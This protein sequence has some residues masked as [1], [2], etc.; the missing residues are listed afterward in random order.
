MALAA[1]VWSQWPTEI[2]ADLADRGHDIMDWHRGAMT[3]RRLLVLLDNAPDTGPYM[4]ARRDGR[5]SRGERV[6]EETFNEI[7]LLRAAFYAVNGDDS[8][9]YEPTILV[10]PID[11]LER[12]R[13]QA[14]DDA[15]QERV[16]AEFEAEIGFS[17]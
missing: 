10:D 5:Q 9:V 12:A 11:E 14:M 7:A 6:R 13:L 1:L 3:S 4:R 2:E 16:T 17:I 8:D 15:E